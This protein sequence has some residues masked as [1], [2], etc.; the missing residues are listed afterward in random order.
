MRPLADR[1]QVADL[2]AVG[3]GVGRVDEDRTLLVEDPP[4]RRVVGEGVAPAQSA[5][6][7]S[8]G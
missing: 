6:R 5:L 1:A 3:A 8:G 4:R 7:R 2:V